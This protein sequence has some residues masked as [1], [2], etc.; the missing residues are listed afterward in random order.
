MWE[1][2]IKEK[3]RDPMMQN[4]VAQGEDLG[5]YPKCNGKLLKV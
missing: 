2:E 4:L 5:L 3:D 1:N